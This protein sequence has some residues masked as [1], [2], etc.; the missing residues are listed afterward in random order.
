MRIVK[1]LTPFNH[2]KGRGGWDVDVIVIHVMQGTMPGTRSW[3]HADRS[4]V[5]ATYGVPREGDEVV[6]YVEE[7]DTHAANGIKVNPRAAIVLERPGVNPNKYSISIEHEG[8]GGQDLTDSQRTLSAWLIAG[9]I[10]RHPKVKLSDRH[11]IPHD[12]IRNDKACPGAIN[13][14][15]LLLAARI[16][17]QP[18]LPSVLTYPRVVWSDYFQRKTGDGWLVVTRYKSDTDWSF[19]PLKQITTKPTKA[20]TALSRMPPGP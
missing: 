17:T 11:I 14:E 7:S 18:A 5:S 6:Q 10:K 15:K 1:D 3:F 20:Q 9:I 2:S 19:V 16:A 8:T 12:R 13:M 4:D